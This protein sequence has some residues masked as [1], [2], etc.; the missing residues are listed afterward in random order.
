[1]TFYEIGGIYSTDSA[2]FYYKSKEDAK[3]GY[4]K[5]YAGGVISKEERYIILDICPELHL[6]Y[7]LSDRNKRGWITYFSWRNKRNY[8][9]HRIM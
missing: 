3:R 1:M 4:L 8:K 5:G 7:I 6:L 9:I 2:I